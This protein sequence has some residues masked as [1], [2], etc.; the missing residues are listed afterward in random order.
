MSPATKSRFSEN[1]IFR[2]A[3]FL[4]FSQLFTWVLSTV[5]AFVLPRYFGPEAAGQLHIGLSLWA[6]TG[7]VIGFGT[8]L[9]ITREIA[10]EP[11][12][13]NE[14]VGSG[15]LLRFGFH[16]IGF[17]ALILYTLVIGYS[18]TVLSV[19]IIYGIANWIGQLGSMCRAA[20]F[21]LESMKAISRIAI[22]VKTART[23][24][25]LTLIVIGLRFEQVILTSIVGSVLFLILQWRALA[26]VYPFRPRPKLATAKR[27]L[28]ESFPIL[29]NRLTRSLYVQLDIIVIS[30]FV[31]ELVVGWYA[32]ADVL[33]GTLLFLPNIFGTAVFPAIARMHKHEPNR[34][35]LFTRRSFHLL[36]VGSVPLGLGVAA[37]ATPAIRL[38]YGEEFAEAG[39]VLSIFG[40]VVIFT[41]LNT[42]LSQQ[43]V[44]MNKERQLTWLMLAAI[45][46]TLPVDL[47]LI[48]W[49]QNNFGNGAI[50]GALAYILTESLITIGAIYLLPRATF[51]R[52]TIW[53]ALKA[54]AAGSLMFA[55]ALL[56]RDSFLLIPIVIGALV[57]IPLVFLF[58][59]ISTE[60]QALLFEISRRQIARFVPSLVAKA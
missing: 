17:A 59:L 31:S 48:P 33:F 42:L 15:M 21:G 19:V 36:L 13:L 58:R 54:T 57:Y 47:I 32:S 28:Q 27:L 4:M 55:I 35:V 3:A 53:L 46:I 5:M 49:T 20:L 39:I 7:L 8:D 25:I 51:D 40:I 50:G 37:I 30:L 24:I 44:A 29:L 56:F 2:N 14:L 22:I 9:V 34:A 45:A 16:I 41:S 18:S 12:N 11:E 1:R 60:D 6:V 52:Y 26:R 10:R 38:I 43:L 23:V